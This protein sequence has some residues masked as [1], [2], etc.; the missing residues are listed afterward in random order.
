M[1]GFMAALLIAAFIWAISALLFLR[2]RVKAF[3]KRKLFA[4]AAGNT[5][6]GAIYAFTRGML[7]GA[8]ENVREN[9]T[10]YALGV[11]YH[12]GIFASFVILARY[13]ICAYS[14][15]FVFH[16]PPSITYLAH[17]LCVLLLALGAAAGVSLL[18]RRVFSHTLRGLSCPDDYIS[19]ILAT[20]TIALALASLLT[21]QT[22]LT[23]A[24][25]FPPASGL[26]LRLTQAW[27]IS[28]II[29]FVY[30]PIGKTR[31]CL[32]FFITRYNLGAFFG[33]RGCMPPQKKGGA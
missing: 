26:A 28:A 29:F 16:V 14:L 17:T 15:P 11:A 5:R 4:K 33:R 6:D 7:P 31:H 10:G 18:V 22:S 3:G 12:T 8:K 25:E 19:N 2:Y 27:L 1:N 9:L 13:I 23:A 21:P 20:A 24:P 32:F 30:I